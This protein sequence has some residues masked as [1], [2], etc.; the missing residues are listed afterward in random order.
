[1]INCGKCGQQGHNAR[2]CPQNGYGSPAPR[3]AKPKKPP[4]A[5]APGSVLEQ[6][7]ARAARLAHELTVVQRVIVDLR[8]LESVR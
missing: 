6:M 2:T 8:E 5:A 3:A 4:V 1:M 7:E